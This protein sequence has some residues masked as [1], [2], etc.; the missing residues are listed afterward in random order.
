MRCWAP[1]HV[2]GMLCRPSETHC[3]LSFK[4]GNCGSWNPFLASA[5]ANPQC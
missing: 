1:L 3:P 4:N 5:Q 2:Y